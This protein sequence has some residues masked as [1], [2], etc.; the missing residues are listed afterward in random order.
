[1]KLFEIAGIDFNPLLLEFWK[2]CTPEQL[3]LYFVQ[4]NCFAASQ[5]LEDYLFKQKRIGNAE[6]IP[7]G[8]IVNGVKKLGWFRTDIPDTSINGFDKKD[9]S[10][11]RSQNLDYKNEHD[12]I[13]YIKLNNLSDE[14]SWIPHSWIEIR[15]TILDP[16][17]FY[18]DGKSGQFDRMVRDKSDIL[19]RYKYF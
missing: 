4:D 13:T 9:L 10:A 11:M 15:G 6:L 16:S 5:D 7:V 1:M 12:R 3:K 19:S 18:I 2:Q 14:F 17:G 8:H